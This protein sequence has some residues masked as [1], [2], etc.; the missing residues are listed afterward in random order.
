VI[1]CFLPLDCLGFLLGN[2]CEKN[3]FWTL[4]LEGKLTYHFMDWTNITS[5]V[6][7]TIESIIEKGGIVPSP[8]TLELLQRKISSYR[9]DI[10][11]IDGFPRNIENIEYWNLMM[12]NSCQVELVL[13]LESSSELLRE[14]LL[15]RAATSARSDDDTSVVSSRIKLHDEITTPVVDHFK[16]LGILE[17]IDGSKSA[18]EV[19]NAIFAV[20]QRRFF[21]E[22]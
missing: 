17:R 3:S 5:F 21:P 7:R 16:K 20:V 18:R 6:F 15:N 12:G 8:I 22:K 9:D 2:F 14:R 1:F 4:T 19:S 11:V 13:F 10:L